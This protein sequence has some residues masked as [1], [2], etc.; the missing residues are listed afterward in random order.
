[1][2]FPY[3]LARPC[4]S[5]ENLA[6]KGFSITAI[7]PAMLPSL[8]SLHMETFGRQDDTLNIVC[9]VLEGLPL[10]ENLFLNLNLVPGEDAFI[11]T[12][13]V[14]LT[15]LQS[16]RLKASC[17]LLLQD[18]IFPA[19]ANLA[20]ACELED[21][22]SDIKADWP[23]SY[24]EQATAIC[25]MVQSHFSQ[26]ASAITDGEI[27]PVHTLH[28]DSGVQLIAV[29]NNLQCE[30]SQ[31]REFSISITSR[32]NVL[33]QHTRDSFS[34]LLGLFSLANVRE[35]T[36]CTVYRVCNTL[37][38]EIMQQAPQLQTLHVDGDGSVLECVTALSPIGTSDLL[39]PELRTLILHPHEEPWPGT[40]DQFYRDLMLGF[41]RMKANG[42]MLDELTL[43][44]TRDYYSILFKRLEMQDWTKADFKIVEAI[45][46]QPT[47]LLPRPAV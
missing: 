10:L 31:R 30:N 20:I 38:M 2:H 6:L 1:M 34:A 13:P 22:S 11:R 16:V 3:V 26:F 14:T 12:K 25:S 45:A 32:K 27:S 18:L 8:T 15:A 44:M 7:N 21:I 29:W 9:E 37:P 40:A 23:T 5:L 42:I 19:T 17:V 43:D 24:I 35:L 4:P 46:K 33:V 47:L 41:E 28:V 36:M 39:Y